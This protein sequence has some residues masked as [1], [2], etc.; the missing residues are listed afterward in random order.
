MD[1]LG[2]YW[3]MKEHY[4]MASTSPNTVNSSANTWAF[5]SLQVR[6]GQIPYGSAGDTT[7]SK[8]SPIHV[9]ICTITP[10]STSHTIHYDG[11]HASTWLANARLYE[12]PLVDYWCV[13]RQR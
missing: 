13:K 12:T 5:M 1:P 6:M 8:Q 10:I 3:C 11:H 9:H 4:H 2:S 7:E